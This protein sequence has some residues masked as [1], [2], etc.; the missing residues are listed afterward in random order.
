MIWFIR[1]RILRVPVTNKYRACKH[2]KWK[3]TSSMHTWVKYICRLVN[4]SFTKAKLHFASTCSFLIVAFLGK[5][6]NNIAFWCLYCFSNLIQ[7]KNEFSWKNEWSRGIGI[8]GCSVQTKEPTV[9]EIK[10]TCRISGQ[11]NGNML[12]HTET[13]CGEIVSVKVR[14]GAKFKIISSMYIL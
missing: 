8:G 4:V 12:F 1:T 11:T 5:R 3:L 13:T 7:E 9:E 6:I 2:P 14:R 10:K